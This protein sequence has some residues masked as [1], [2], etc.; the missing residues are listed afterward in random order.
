ML[1]GSL[2]M[3]FTKQFPWE[4]D[5][6]DKAGGGGGS[7]VFLELGVK[8]LE[9]IAVSAA[10]WVCKATPNSRINTHGGVLEI[11]I[12]N[13]GTRFRAVTLHMG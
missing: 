2:E 13:L 4:S 11:D 9:P 5:R 7:C 6:D 1:L 8:S 10:L 12:N 3:V